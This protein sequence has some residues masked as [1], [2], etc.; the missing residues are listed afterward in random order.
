MLP[1]GI[2]DTAAFP[3]WEWMKS[4]SAKWMLIRGRPRKKK[5]LRLEYKLKIAYEVHNG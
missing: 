1:D 4:R 2:R 5:E 3:S